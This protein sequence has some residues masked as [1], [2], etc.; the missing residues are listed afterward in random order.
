M[1]KMHHV[2]IYIYKNLLVYKRLDYSEQRTRLEIIVGGASRS[3]Q[4]A[5]RGCLYR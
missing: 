4:E 5:S 2:V 3:E 1:S